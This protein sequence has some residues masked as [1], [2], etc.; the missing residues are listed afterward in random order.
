[1]LWL[2][3]QAPFAV[4]RT[5]TAGSFRP[6]AP[7]MPPSAAYGL[8]LN[9]ASIEMRHD[10]GKSPM[11][12]IAE[13]I[14]E[15]EIA[16]GAVSQPGRHSLYQQ[17]H[18]YPVGNS[19]AK[20][21]PACKGNKYNIT[22]ARRAFLS[23]LRASVGLRG[24]DTLADRI[25]TGL[26]GQG[27]RE[28]GLPFLGDNNFLPDRIDVLPE[29]RAARWLVPM[30]PEDQL[31]PGEEPMRLTLSIDRADMSKTSSQLYRMEAECSKTVPERAWSRVGPS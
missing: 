20:H 17:L 16:L 25:Q 8:L 15:A 13:D 27:S 11:T 28:Y 4:F 9:L 3:I 18:N 14:P 10:D 30:Q 2:Y 1:M 31:E 24:N 21:A 22:P 5:F 29:P 6:S 26:S 23:G 7:F 19:G 12:L